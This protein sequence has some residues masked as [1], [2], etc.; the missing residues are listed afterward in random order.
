MTFTR[1]LLITGGM[2]FIGSN[3]V[4]VLRRERPGWR[5]INLDALTYA[6]HTVTLDDLRDDPGHVF[7][8][9]DIT[10]PDALRHVF[11]T[12]QPDGVFHLAAESHVDRSIDAPL[13]FVRTNVEG[14]VH[15]L[16]QARQAWG[17]R[18]DVRFV[19]VST[20]EVFGDLGPDDPPFSEDTPYHPQSP[21]AASKAAADHMARAW[22]HTFALPVVITSCTNNYGP[23]QL[24][25]KL[26]P[27]VITRALRQEPVPV[28]GQGLNV[29]DWLFV[30]DH[31]LALLAAFERGQPG[32]TYGIG[33]ERE[34]RN[35]D[36]VHATLDAV[37]QHLH[38][39]PGHSR[40]LV[41][42]VTDRP[43]HD[44]RYAMNI[45]RARREL[46]WT[47]ST[48]LEDGLQRTVAW[49]LHHTA[50]IDAVTSPEHRD[51]QTRW[52]QHRDAPPQ[53]AP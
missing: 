11:D 16:Q 44:R 45:D 6:G 26:L 22:A 41:R 33:G 43:G 4:R 39:P 19:H 49:Y 53:D 24:P 7:V 36:L 30:E 8:R 42:F 48:T 38:R 46:G 25:E 1:T 17:D 20:D 10:D 9:A 52:Y 32:R 51:F 37:D 13:A 5:L 2:G 31:A 12:F 14:T 18:R 15:L 47:P 35:I 23:A 27:V 34:V 40:P 3:L 21:Y 29:R 28:Y 50:W